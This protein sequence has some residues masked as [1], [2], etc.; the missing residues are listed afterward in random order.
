MSR[1]S[2]LGSPRRSELLV[3]GLELPPM[4]LTA[5]LQSDLDIHCRERAVSDLSSDESLARELADCD[6]V[7]V[8]VGKDLEGAGRLVERIMSTT[9]K[10][11]V[12][13]RSSER[14]GGDST[15]WDRLGALM[16]IDWCPR[17]PGTTRLIREQIRQAARVTPVVHARP[18]SRWSERRS[19]GGRSLPESTL[20]RARSRVPAV[21]IVAIGA[22]SGGPRAVTQLIAELP[23]EFPA[24]VLVVQHLTG[25]FIPN[26]ARALGRVSP[27]KAVV[28]TD[29]A[30]LEAGQVMIAPDGLHLV[31]SEEGRARLTPTSKFADPNNT[32]SVDALLTSVARVCGANAC[33]ILLS[34]MGRDGARGALALRQAGG[35]VWTQDEASCV[36][37]GMPKAAFD[38]QA[39]ER[40]AD[41][42]ELGRMLRQLFPPKARP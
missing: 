9:P 6:V 37:Y 35:R 25:T 27:L 11:L 24:C 32:P 13:L 22:S 14:A 36:V 5:S 1:G 18:P 15:R 31:V 41:P 2:D 28:A 20:A 39:V 34:G 21:P 40:Q 30:C 8:W 7:A 26:F 4:L 10:P 17:A 3:L 38:L 19:E 16:V 33:G 42:A 29:G 12:M 23:A